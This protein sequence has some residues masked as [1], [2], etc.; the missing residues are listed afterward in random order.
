MNGGIVHS[1]AALDLFSKI[2]DTR[3]QNLANAN[4]IGY[5][6]RVSSA[7]AYSRISR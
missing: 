4:T 7:E 2:Q 5:C 3:A 1:V 6:K